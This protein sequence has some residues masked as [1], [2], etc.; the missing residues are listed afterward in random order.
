LTVTLATLIPCTS[1]SG[2]VNFNFMFIILLLAEESDM[3]LV[4]ASDGIWDVLSNEQ[5]AKL[6][7]TQSCYLQ[8]DCVCSDAERLKWTARKLCEK[9]K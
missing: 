3:F 2:R 9:A 5:V 4:I 1:H 8:D 6:V 7:I